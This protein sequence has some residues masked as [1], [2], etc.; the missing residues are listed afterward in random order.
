MKTIHEKTT[1]LFFQSCLRARLTAII[2]P[3]FACAAC[4]GALRPPT[5]AEVQAAYD[6]EATA[7]NTKHDKNLQILSIVRC[8]KPNSDKYT[9]LIEFTSRADPKEHL[10]YDVV[11][12][13]NQDGRLKL[14]SGLCRST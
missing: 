1:S 10:Y 7:A 6:R 5:V 12:V 14:K 8:E 11:S 13:A 3:E 2:I 9:C 4:Q